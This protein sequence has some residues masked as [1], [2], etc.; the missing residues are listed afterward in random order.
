M[1]R[2][3]KIRL[4]RLE[5]EPVKQADTLGVPKGQKLRESERSGLNLISVSRIKAESIILKEQTNGYL[6]RSNPP[7]YSKPRSIGL[8]VS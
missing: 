3:T 2:K 7:N 4:N 6:E 1:D 8:A 5:R